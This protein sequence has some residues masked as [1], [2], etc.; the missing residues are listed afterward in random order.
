MALLFPGKNGTA[1]PDESLL[2]P[3]N[4]DSTT[5]AARPVRSG[6]SV[7]HHLEKSSDRTAAARI[8][9]LET[10][11]RGLH[12]PVQGAP[13]RL[14]SARAR[15]DT[16]LPRG[17]AVWRAAAPQVRLVPTTSRGVFSVETT[18]YIVT[19]KKNHH[20][21][22]PHHSIAAI[23]PPGGRSCA[24]VRSTTRRAIR[25][26]R[27]ADRWPDRLLAVVG[28]HGSGGEPGRGS[29]SAWWFAKGMDDGSRPGSRAASGRCSRRQIHE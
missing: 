4:S 8:G 18:T 7:T 25:P 11:R 12:S 16:S 9:R 3:P 27:R 2:P 19:K 28:S 5:P 10:A 15:A 17:P 23:D 29:G 13:Q 21:Y 1:P 24:V 14:I 20:L 22:R 6:A 26:S